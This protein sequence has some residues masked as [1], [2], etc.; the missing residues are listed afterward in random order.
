M[1]L[2]ALS[3]TQTSRLTRS[4]RS[5][6]RQAADLIVAAQLPFG[7]RFGERR[8]QRRRAGEEHRV[9]GF[10]HGVAQRNREM[11]FADAGRTEE[12]HK[13][14]H[15]AAKLIGRSSFGASTCVLPEN[16]VSRHATFAPD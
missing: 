12:Q 10:D 13:S 3:V 15:E 4:G 8:E 11:R 14:Q 6:C 16:G 5:N 9:A 1:S 2:Q 7:F